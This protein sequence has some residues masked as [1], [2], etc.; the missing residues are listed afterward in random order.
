MAQNSINSTVNILSH[1][2]TASSWAIGHV[3]AMVSGCLFNTIKKKSFTDTLNQKY[4][5]K[6]VNRLFKAMTLPLLTEY[7]LG[8][9]LPPSNLP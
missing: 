6:S 9:F 5:Q 1:S 4:L 8:L 7:W 3:R 2:V